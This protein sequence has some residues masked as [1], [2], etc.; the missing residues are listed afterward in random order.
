LLQGNE[1]EELDE[2]SQTYKGRC[3]YNKR[4]YCYREPEERTLPLCQVCQ[5]ARVVGRL[6]KIVKIL[7]RKIP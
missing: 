6:D 2:T 5:L 7:E 4:L 1:K 3:D